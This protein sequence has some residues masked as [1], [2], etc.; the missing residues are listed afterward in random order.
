MVFIEVDDP[1][2]RQELKGR[3]DVEVRHDFPNGFSAT[4]PATARRGIEQR[5]GVAV[6]DVP[7]HHLSVS[8]SDQTPYGIKQIYD[9]TGITS[10]SGGAGVVIGHLDTG[11]NKDHPDLVNRI[12]GCND[13]TKRGIR[14]GCNDSNGHGTHTAG[15]ALADGASGSGI[16]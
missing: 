14:N 12:V 1:Q 3:A 11:V 5:P 6:H 15:T 7:I 10:T 4:I 8:P 9:D 16:F 2:S 13:A